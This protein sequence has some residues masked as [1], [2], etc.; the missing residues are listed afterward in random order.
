MNSAR[1]ATPRRS[2]VFFL[3]ALAGS[4][5]GIVAGPRI[6]AAFQ[7]SPAWLLP[8]VLCVSV[9]LA[10]IAA[11]LAFRFAGGRAVLRNRP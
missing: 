4:I 11:Y 3:F 5:T 7:G 6:V 2:L 10:L 8:A 1:L 9:L